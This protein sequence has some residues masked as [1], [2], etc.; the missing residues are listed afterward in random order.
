M[1][2]PAKPEVVKVVTTSKRTDD[3]TLPAWRKRVKPADEE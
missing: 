2:E 3:K 1:P